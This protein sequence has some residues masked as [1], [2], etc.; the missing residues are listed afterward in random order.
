MIGKLEVCCGTYAD[1]M[2][3]VKGG[4]DRVELCS[5]LSCG[6]VTPS[7]SLIAHVCG[8]CSK[9]LPVHV[10]IRPRE[11]GFVYTPEEVEIMEGDIRYAKAAG[12]AGVVIG[13]LHENDEIDMDNC[14]RLMKAA[15]GMS[16]TFSRAFD[17]VPDP[18]AALEQVKELGCDR[19]LTS[20]CAPTA[21][22]GAKVIKALQ[23]KA[24]PVI[25]LAGS[26]VN[27]NNFAELMAI[28]GVGEIHGSMRG[29]EGQNA[30]SA[31]G[32]VFD[33]HKQVSAEKVA[34]IT[35]AIHN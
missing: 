29:G 31:S 30:R 32:V 4:A 5:A 13:C 11:G 7:H 10:L 19:I 26:G 22:E 23:E 2:A 9:Y 12:A 24:A 20:G 15:D 8:Q 28:T 3:A 33:G 18:M 21:M 1:V 27:E 16:V 14:R 35:G 34:K 6:G 25:I 17:L